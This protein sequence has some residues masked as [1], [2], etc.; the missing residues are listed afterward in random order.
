MSA[1]LVYWFYA[2]VVFMLNF[3]MDWLWF[4]A[5]GRLAGARVR[6]W[7]L[8]AAAAIGAAASVWAFF[9][10]GQWLYAPLSKILGTALLFGIAYLPCPLS[11]G[12]GLLFTFVLTGITMAGMPLVVTV[13]QAGG[14]PKLLPVVRVP[15]SFLVAF[16]TP[17]AMVGA[18]VLW[19]AVRARSRL[20]EG[21]CRLRI[22][23][24]GKEVEVDGFL[25][26]GNSLKEPLTALPVAVVETDALA[27]LLPEALLAAVAAGGPAHLPWDFLSDLPHGASGLGRFT[28]VPY[29]SVGQP[30][31]TM[32]AFAPESLA[33]RPSSS[34]QWREVK[35]LVAVTADRLH[36][37][38]AYHALLPPS[39]IE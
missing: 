10:S 18:R 39:M 33:V 29:H 26:T 22:K 19:D 12:V 24:K 34:S 36:P 15:S 16:G 31:S 13:L 32:I 35:G 9:P 4:W 17:L 21:L 20:K 23:G 25:D 2:D 8:L 3:A 5:A 37:T 1:H 7:R 27:P 11:Q 38:G 14:D 28:L 30:G 6:G